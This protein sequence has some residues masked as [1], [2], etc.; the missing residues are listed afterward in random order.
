DL[1]SFGR[2]FDVHPPRVKL[3]VDRTRIPEILSQL[4][5]RYPI[6]DVGVQDR[7]LEE[8]IAE[9]F[10]AKEVGSG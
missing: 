1:D 8:V 6:E 3:E 10:T 9:V 4:L 7:P 2:V 5:S